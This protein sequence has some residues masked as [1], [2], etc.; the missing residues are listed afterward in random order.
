MPWFPELSHRGEWDA[1]ESAN[2]WFLRRAAAVITGT[3]TGADEIVRF[4]QVQPELVHI[5]PHPTPDFALRAAEAGAAD[6]MAKYHV[7]SPYLI[8]PAQFWAHKNHVNLLLALRELRNT[9]GLSVQLV[10]LG[11]DKGN[12]AYCEQIAA[13]LGL[14][15][16]LRLLGFVPR[17]D[18]IAL[19]RGRRAGLCIVR[20]A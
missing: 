1:R 8:Y 20:R 6:V 16:A 14:G 5:L 7:E 9:H 10:L 2:A 13:D 4:Y 18:L 15:D 19:Y 17:E 12:R 11:S 3:R